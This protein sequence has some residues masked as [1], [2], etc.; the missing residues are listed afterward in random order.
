MT[1]SQTNSVTDLAKADQRSSLIRRIVL[2]LIVILISGNVGYRLGVKK[3]GSKPQN[4]PKSVVINT[5]TPINREVDFGLFWEVWS[6][7]EQSFID[8]EKLDAR[9]MVYGAIAGMVNSL[10]DPYTV[11]LTPEQNGDFKEDLQG[12][13]E[14]IG[15]QL[16]EKDDRIVVIA[17]LADSPA[18]KAGLKAGDWIIKVD[19]EET[20]NWTV[21]EAVTKI[22][23]QRGTTVTLNILHEGEQNPVDIRVVRDTIVLKSVDV[24]FKK[25]DENCTEACSEVA[26]VKLTRFGDGTN[27][28][29]NA[30]VSQIRERYGSGFVR[31]IILDVRNNPGGYFQSAIHVASEFIRSGVIVVQENANGTKETFSVNRLGNL[32][33]QKLVVLINKGSA[34]AAEIVAGAIRDHNRG[35]LI[36]EATFGKG[37]VQSPEDLADGS[38]LHITTARWIMPKGEWINGTGIKPDIEV[39]PQQDASPSADVQLERAIAEF[40]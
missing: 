31:G 20:V 13:F 25:V 17:P 12:S 38:G 2:W 11:F 7:L 28:E 8:K 15:A 37:S 22:R 29:W 34:S 3:I 10:G 18:E 39:I 30:A 24:E 21:P 1:T 40:K 23:G 32:L 14:G 16:G 6:K 36:G 26:W 33:N 35:K 9:T 27:D 19:G 5:E 4:L